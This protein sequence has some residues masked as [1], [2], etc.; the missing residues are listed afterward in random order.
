MSNQPKTQK[1][2]YAPK[3]PR[4]I[5]KLGSMFD[6]VVAALSVAR[7]CGADEDELPRV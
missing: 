6:H 2:K 7:G 3:R 5:F 1:T 4:K